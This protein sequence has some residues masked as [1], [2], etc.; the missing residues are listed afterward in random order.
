MFGE[1]RLVELVRSSEETSAQ[2]LLE[3]VLA[4]IDDWS[5]DSTAYQDD[6]TLLVLNCVGSG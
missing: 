6:C 4:T 3:E 5:K 1:E 2:G